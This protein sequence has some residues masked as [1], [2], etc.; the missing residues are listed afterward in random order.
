MY[1]SKSGGKNR[2]TLF[3]FDTQPGAAPVSPAAS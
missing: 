3:S 1:A 2:V